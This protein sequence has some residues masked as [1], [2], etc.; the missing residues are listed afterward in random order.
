MKLASH[1]KTNR[2]EGFS[3]IELLTVVSI[4]AILG[5][6]AMPAMQSALTNAQLARATA[7]ARSI[8]MGLRNYAADNEGTFP[9]EEDLEGNPIATSNDAFR[10][11]VPYY[12]DSEK[13]FA[14]KRSAWG[15]QADGRQD[16]VSE[17]LEAGENHYAYI[18]G[19]SDTSQS[20][21]PLVVDGTNG[22]GMY[23]T[24]RGEKGGAW[25]A[26]KAI[27]AYVGGHVEAVVLRGPRDG[28]R[29][30]PREGYPEENALMLNYMNDDA[31]L[32]EPAEG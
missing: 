5:T 2:P 18:A 31:E 24:E 17:I 25:E 20:S 19:L 16:D 11:L 4:M 30:I 21:W 32:L 1:R 23:V 27:V 28:E 22:S 12:I 26:R 15:Q 9:F 3:L 29:H 8:A 6:I 10:A 7:N 13:I 14:L